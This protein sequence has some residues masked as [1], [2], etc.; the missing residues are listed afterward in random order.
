MSNNLVQHFVN[1]CSVFS[2]R[3]LPELANNIFETNKFAKI[4]SK[5]EVGQ[6]KPE[7]PNNQNLGIFSKDF[8][9]KDSEILR[10]STEKA[11]TGLQLHDSKYREASNLDRKINKMVEEVTAK[12]EYNRLRLP[13]DIKIISQ[14]FT[15]A[16]DKNFQVHDYSSFLQSTTMPINP[17]L[18]NPN[19]AKFV[20]TKRLK[21]SIKSMYQYFNLLSDKVCNEIFPA[22]DKRMFY[23]LM[24]MIRSRGLCF[25]PQKP[26]EF[27]YGDVKIQCPIVDLMN[28]SFTNNC[29]IDGDYSNMSDTS[30]IVVRAANDI[31]PGEELTLNY[32]NFSS[33][34]LFTR[35]GMLY[36][37]NPHDNLEVE[38]SNEKL[39]EYSTKLYDLKFKILRTGPDFDYDTI[40]IYSNRFHKNYLSSLRILFLSEDDVKRKPSIASNIYMN[41]EEEIS[42]NNE[43]LLTNYLYDSFKS[44]LDEINQAKEKLIMEGVKLYKVDAP[45]NPAEIKQNLLISVQE[46]EEKILLK[47]LDFF[48]KRQQELINRV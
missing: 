45:N 32:G 12:D 31:M 27:N 37:N 14:V 18:L 42:Q 39:E 29:V 35:F 4:Y 38:L 28:H 9:R 33:L 34:E 20:Y 40:K 21:S 24:M 6:G 46:N 23:H 25:N 41:F 15:A 48:A 13:Q 22:V 8:I 1:S 30:Y 2:K 26:L 47:N 43:M 7:Q 11:I 10:I 36:E 44:E 5:I 16:L 3:R 17:L 19:D